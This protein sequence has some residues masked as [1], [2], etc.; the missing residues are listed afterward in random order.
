MIDDWQLTWEEQHWVEE[1]VLDTPDAWELM[2]PEELAADVEWCRQQA[3]K[4][5]HA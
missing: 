3:E 4:E 5:S 2:T 1:P